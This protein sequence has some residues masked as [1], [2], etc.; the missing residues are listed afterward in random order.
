[1][2]AAQCFCYNLSDMNPDKEPTNEIIDLPPVA[3]V[4][5]RQE[6]DSTHQVAEHSPEILRQPSGTQVK[7]GSHKS[8]VAQSAVKDDPA[9]QA[10]QLPQSDDVGT[11]SF[12]ADDADLIEKEWVE[13]AKDIVHKTK[14]NPYLQ[15]KAITKMKADYIKKRYNKD[16]R[17]QED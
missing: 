16:I 5:Q 9:S 1:M 13:R 6:Q 14:D 2:L 15:N 4:E 10:Q 12:I 3:P 8:T 17:L 11:D 7:S